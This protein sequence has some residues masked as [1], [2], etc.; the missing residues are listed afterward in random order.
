[1]KDEELIEKTRRA[2]TEVFGAQVPFDSSLSRLDDSRWTSLK[3]IELL[4][5]LER[6]CGVR[7]DGADATD[8]VS[9]PTILQRIR[10]R[11]G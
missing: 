2:F 7:F 11:L 3:H 8:M 1:M 9:I 10:E 5:A 4:I 6:Q